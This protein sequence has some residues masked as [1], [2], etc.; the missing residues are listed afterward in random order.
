[1]KVS[2]RLSFPIYTNGANVLREERLDAFQS[3]HFTYVDKKEREKK[4][5]LLL[6]IP[7]NLFHVPSSFL[8]HSNFIYL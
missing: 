2:L 3:L 4:A 7:H 6:S 5:V 8:F 1:M